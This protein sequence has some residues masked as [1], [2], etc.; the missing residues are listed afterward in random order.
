[1][2][3]LLAQ[4][5]PGGVQQTIDKLART[6]LSQII[7]LVVVCTVLRFAMAPYLARVPVHRRTGSYAAAR[8]FNE[9]LDAIVYAGVFVFLVI[10]PFGLQTFVIPSESMV[11]TLLVNDFIVANKA[12]YRYT[13]PQIGDI[14]VFRPPIYAC[15]DNQIAADGTVNADFIKRC[16]GTPGDIVEIRDGTLYRNGQAINEPYVLRKSPWDFKLAKVTGIVKENPENKEI[17][18]LAMVGDQVNAIHSAPIALPFQ[19]RDQLVMDK[20]REAPAAA[21]PPG[22]FLFMGDNRP[23]SFDGRG[24]GLISEQDIIGRA[25]FIWMPISRIRKLR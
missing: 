21:I 6:P 10:R 15:N 9:F 24:W 7:M 19:V 12:I 22:H 14:V 17:W 25:E 11:R 18:P 8:I 23:G 4:Q 3:E 13:K 5:E 16:V 1:V 2:L 20:L